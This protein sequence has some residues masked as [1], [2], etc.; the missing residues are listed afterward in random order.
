MKP[1]WFGPEERPLFGWLHAPVDG[2]A[3]GAVVLCPALGTE[4][5]NAR[6]AF[7]RLAERLAD[8]GFVA[9]R[10]NYDGTGD[11]AGRQDDPGRTE[12]WL[13]DVRAALTFVRTLGLHQVSVVG[14]RMGATL[15]VEALGASL[16][17]VNALVLWDPCPS[18]HTFLRE[19]VALWS[20]A[21]GAR[22]NEDGSVETPGVVYSQETAETLS[23]VALV[24][25][26]VLADHTLVLARAG[27]RGD[28]KT[29][30]QLE[31]LGAQRQE[32][33]G[34]EDLLNVEPGFAEVPHE[35]L[36]I[37]CDWL[38][39]RADDET[40]AV[41][42]L[43]TAGRSDAVVGRTSD[44]RAIRERPVAIGSA[45]LFGIVAAADIDHRDNVRSESAPAQAGPGPDR[46][47]TP[48]TVYFLN[49][50]VLDH[51]GP[52]GIWV[53]LSRAWAAA[54][55]RLVRFDFTGLGDSPRKHDRRALEYVYAP[56]TIDEVLTAMRELSP[57]DP[58]NSILVGLCSGGYHAVEGAINGKTRGVCAV[59]PS[60]SF[61]PP[62]IQVHS[63][64]ELQT[65]VVDTRRQASG[66]KKSWTRLIPSARGRLGP[67]VQR[68]PDWT[69]W[70]WNRTVVDSSP[71]R[72][73]AKVL[74]NGT[75]MV[76]VAG[77]GEGRYLMRGEHGRFRRLR[78]S[79]RFRM[80]IIPDLEHTLFERTGREQVLGIL[81]AHVVGHYGAPTSH[82]DASL[83]GQTG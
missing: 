21:Y 82:A 60:L 62:E 44:G 73:L 61:T 56:E 80:E 70:F 34:Q 14:L 67:L 7:R 2:R 38:A 37:L 40:V 3:R 63:P 4:A 31:G 51:V 15:A 48:P 27:R 13:G 83:P 35:T 59:N 54:G 17:S 20:M 81:T 5:V 74:D 16:A 26:T 55:L 29:N 46:W 52:A 24:N 42:N 78:R 6:D 72:T 22:A 9:L 12:A 32:V 71:A 23:R 64:V 50:G 18:G 68:L 11:S 19:Q 53:Q 65:S 8:R 30:A 47:S 41:A 25:A 77:P 76:V 10:F 57:G 79:G 36:A 33:R 75:D 28:R 69:W 39:D 49:A 66:A 45:P 1:L 58:S 43:R